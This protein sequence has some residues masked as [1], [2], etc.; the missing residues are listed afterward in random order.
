MVDTQGHVLNLQKPFHPV[1]ARKGKGIT[2]PVK[3]VEQVKPSI[4]GWI[5][6]MEEDAEIGSALLDGRPRVEARP[7]PRRVLVGVIPLSNLA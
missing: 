7:K 6:G 3:P 4:M 1:G 2:D 5:E